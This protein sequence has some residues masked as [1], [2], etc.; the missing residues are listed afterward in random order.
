MVSF[1]KLIIRLFASGELLKQLDYLYYMFGSRYWILAAGLSDYT[2][3]IMLG[4]NNFKDI[5]KC[6]K[7]DKK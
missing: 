6:S 4:S 2:I 3:Y 5:L 7:E 1:N